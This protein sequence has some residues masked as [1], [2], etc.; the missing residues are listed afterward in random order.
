MS[1]VTKLSLVLCRPGFDTAVSL[2]SICT[3]QVAHPYPH[4][5]PH[6]LQG[7]RS[8]PIAC[9]YLKPVHTFLDPL[10]LSEM[11][12]W[13]TPGCRNYGGVGSRLTEINSEVPPLAACGCGQAPS[14]GFLRMSVPLT[15]LLT[16]HGNQIMG[17]IWTPVGDPET[18]QSATLRTMTHT[19]PLGQGV[20]RANVA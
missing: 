15:L 14:Q 12:F 18:D 5:H 19:F 17:I 16:L 13:E 7:V 9:F 10:L 20:H 1:L 3:G 2:M 11:V 8:P 6:P 4:L